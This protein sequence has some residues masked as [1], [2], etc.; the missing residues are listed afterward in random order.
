MI[1]LYNSGLLTPDE[2]QTIFVNW[3]D[4]I[5]ENFYNILTAEEFDTWYIG[6][7]IDCSSRLVKAFIIRQRTCYSGI[8]QMIG[9]I[10]CQHVRFGFKY[11]FHF[12]WNLTFYLVFDR[13]H[14]LRSTF[15]F[16]VLNC[17]RQLFFRISVNLQQSLRSIA[18]L[19]NLT[20]TRK[21]CHYRR[22]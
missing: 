2:L 3:D 6:I 8:I 9:D 16:V 1:P 13:F 11:G 14:R 22:F 12:H 10:L 15:G 19:Y 17:V 20:L 4:L 7:L 21:V 5:G 18:N